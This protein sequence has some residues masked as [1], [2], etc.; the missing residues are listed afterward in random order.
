MPAGFL[1]AKLFETAF[2]EDFT[3]RAVIQSKLETAMG[4]LPAILTSGVL[5][6]LS[7]LGANLHSMGRHF[8][9]LELILTLLSQMTI[10]WL[11]GIIFMKTRSL[12]PQVICHFSI[13]WMA[14]I[15]VGLPFFN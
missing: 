13:N 6:G 5:F 11:L 14:V 9:L 2:L 4:Q 8:D 12:W 10:G 1:L 3:Y 15:L 7:H